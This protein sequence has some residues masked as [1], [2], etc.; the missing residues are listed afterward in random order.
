MANLLD[1]G[2]MKIR[3][4]L[5]R[6]C[7]AAAVIILPVMGV[8]AVSAAPAQAAAC[9]GASCTGRNPEGACNGDARTVGA[10]NVNLNGSNEGMIELRWSQSCTA[11]WGRFTPYWRTEAGYAASG[12]GVWARVTVW[13]P[14]APSQDTAHHADFFV[15]RSVDVLV[16]D[17]RSTTR[18]YRRGSLPCL[19][20]GQ[21]FW[22]AR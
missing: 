16:H 6:F 12:I 10:M 14:G 17:R 8:V 21:P 7:V 9:Y 1:W 13:N 5:Q 4:A 2:D 18:L 22:C 11:N 3:E 20:R 15:C 19:Q